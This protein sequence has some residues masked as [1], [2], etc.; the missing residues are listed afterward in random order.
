M[1]KE[2]VKANKVEAPTLF[3]GVGGTGCNIVTR[4]AEMCRPGETE[5]ISFVCLDTNVNDLTSVAKSQA[6]IYHVQTSNTQTVGDYLAYDQDALKNWFPK[7][8][9]IYDKTVSEGA[10]QV[11]AISRLALNSTIKTGKINPLYKA[12]DDLFRKDGKEM[13]QALRIVIVSTA[14]GGTGSGIA[15]PL[16]MFVRD[17]VSSKYPNTSLIVRSMILL[18]ETLDSVIDSSVERDSQRRNAYATIKEINA[19]MM[20]GSGFLDVESDLKRYSD[21]HIDFPIAGTDEMRPLSVLPFD[22]CFLMDGQDAEDSTLISLDQYKQQAAQALYEQNIGPMQRNAFSVEDNIIKE[23]SNPG[24]Y[25]R[26]RFGAIGAATLRY[27]Y[28]KIA[29]YVA[30]NWLIDAVGGEGEASKWGRYDAAFKQKLAEGRKQG[31]SSSELPKI[32]DVYNATIDTSSDNFSKDLRAKFLNRQD[33]AKRLDAYMEA[34]Q[35]EMMD[36]LE[37]NS[38]IMNAKTEAQGVKNIDFSDA[39]QRGAGVATSTLEA[40]RGY[41]NAV[42]Q[43]AKDAAAGMAESIFY[44]D[45]KTIQDS[46]AHTLENLMKNSYGEICHPCAMRYMLYA[47]K[48]RFAE[49]RDEA[50][51]ARNDAREALHRYA[52]DPTDADFSFGKKKITSINALVALD[53]ASFTLGEKLQGAEKA[54]P[55]ILDALN[56]YYEAINTLAEKTAEF[57]AYNTGYAYVEALAKNMEDFFATF[58]AKV[59]SMELKKDDLINELKFRKGDSVFNVCAS[60]DLLEE[61]TLATKATARDSEMLDDDVNAKIFDGVKQNV[62]F[63]RETQAMDVIEEDHSVDLFDD[64]M[65]GYYKE[66]VRRKCAKQLDL[67]I[68]HALAM[69]KR[70]LNR[71]QLREQSGDAK[72]V[73]KVTTEDAERY[74]KEKISMGERLA[75]PSVQRMRN[76]ES[77]EIALCSYNKSLLEIRDFRIKELMPKGNAVESISRYELRFFNALYNLT[78]DRLNKFS[79]AKQSETTKKRGGLYH[80][81]YTA[82]ARDIGPD[83][84]KGSKISTHIDKRWDSIAVMPELDLEHQSREVMKIHQAMIYGLVYGSI[85]KVPLSMVAKKKDVYKFLNSEE[86]FVTLTVS[87]NSPC[88]EFYEILDALYVSAFL[89]KDMDA[90]RAKKAYKDRLQNAKFESTQFYESLK[91][92]TLADVHPEGERASLFEI[93]MACYASMPSGKRFSGEMAAMVDAIIKTLEDEL[94]AYEEKDDV[95]FKLCDILKEQFELLAKNY[96]KYPEVLSAGLSFKDNPIQDVITRKITHV[97]E[98]TPE[99]SDYMEMLE[100]M[101]KVIH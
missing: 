99:P 2:N 91:K 62:A 24:N 30:Y 87:N 6:K 92:F 31:K 28:E 71:L 43:N 90:I 22:F 44:N 15:L 40:L 32:E 13:K 58:T 27:P 77:R 63:Q 34:L 88:D 52:E 86:R 75:A 3:I 85:A 35:Q 97:V 68:V 5:N 14:S 74:I 33:V 17:H 9:V 66:D 8:A 61:M 54:Y 49:A 72:V 37:A 82:Y 29:D 79:A 76:V 55:E 47:V 78:P 11:R 7:N 98:S 46:A 70:M 67:D 56:A 80:L 16:A 60:K 100:D 83:S 42:N 50:K 59:R 36:A 39:T 45:R 101:K 65:L 26:N 10:G 25:G 20:K 41:E 95:K 81:A 89:V 4:V 12:I 96:E 51:D 23:M 53:K 57:E 38:N 21:L 93:P 69:E 1:A 64:V 48:K 18:P 94:S 19:F 73:D 84:T